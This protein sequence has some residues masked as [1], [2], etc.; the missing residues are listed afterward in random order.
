MVPVRVD[1]GR[2][3]RS[4]FLTVLLLLGVLPKAAAATSG[5]MRNDTY[6]VRAVISSGGGSTLYVGGKVSYFT[7]GGPATGEVVIPARRIL[8]GLTQYWLGTHDTT[9]PTEFTLLNPVDDID[10]N[11]NWITFRW[12]E[13]EDSSHPISYRL[14]VDTDMAGNYVVDS[15]VAETSFLRVAVAPNDTYFWRIVASDIRGNSRTVGDSLLRIYTLTP[16]TLVYPV[17]GVE[18]T[19]TSFLFDWIDGTTTGPSITDYQFQVANDT[20]FDTPILD[21]FHNFGTSE[22]RPLYLFTAVDTF[23]WRMRTRD[24]LGNFSS[25]TAAETIV[26]LAPAETMAPLAVRGFTLTALDTGAILITWQRSPSLDVVQYNLSWDEGRGTAADTLL[27]VVGQDTSEFLRF[28]TTML[29]NG[30]EYRFQVVAQDTNGNQGPAVFGSVIARTSAPTVANGVMEFPEAGTKIREGDSALPIFFTLD[31]TSQQIDSAVSFLLQYRLFPNG[32]WTDMSPSTVA[33]ENANPIAVAKAKTDIG[34]YRFVWDLSGLAADT[35][36]IRVIVNDDQGESSWLTAASVSTL[37]VDPAIDSPSIQTTVLRDG[38]KVDRVFSA[39]RT[40]T[41]PIVN[42]TDTQ[43]GYVVLP[44]GAFPVA[45]DTA[46][47]FLSVSIR[48]KAGFDTDLTS[49]TARPVWDALEVSVSSGD[50][51]MAGNKTATVHLTFRDDNQDGFVDGTFVRWNTLKIMRHSGIPG[52]AWEEMPTTASQDPTAD[53][54]GFLETITAHFSIFRLVGVAASPNLSTFMVAPNPF[55]PNDGVDATGR[56]FTGAPGTGIYFL[57]LPLKV[58]IRVFTV[59]GRKVFDFQTNN[60]TGQ[61]QWDVTNEVGQPIASG[62][63]IYVVEDL[64]T[65]NKKTGKLVVIR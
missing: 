39:N 50:T 52:D 65:G 29:T 7:N 21:F 57:N 53:T 40:E 35:Y 63:Y 26:R 3:L 36:E 34:N 30:K 5:F 46:G 31:G 48:S 32:A 54:P 15:T 43:G 49:V 33:S 18:T 20:A 17:G 16:P 2:C 45:Q 56:N 64:G 19:A 13:A 27:A 62:V 24:A 6:T 59:A 60:S 22:T 38:L 14:I 61:V 11:E 44:D 12:T 42:G 58:R 25:W 4:F 28:L 1:V 23:Y 8:A 10:T 55:R 9:P 41:F 37:I 47:I 51:E